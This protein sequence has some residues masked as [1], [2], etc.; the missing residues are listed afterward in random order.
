[1]VIIAIIKT[2]TY[3]TRISDRSHTASNVVRSPNLRAPVTVA[4]IA[5]L[6]RS[7]SSGRGDDGLVNGF[8]NWGLES[9]IFMLLQRF[10]EA[11]R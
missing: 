3:N 4:H 1:M 10:V 11:H 9:E 7:D 6:V 5:G 8:L 2:L